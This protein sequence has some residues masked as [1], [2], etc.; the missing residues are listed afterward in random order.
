MLWQ[1]AR[2]LNI[3]KANDYRPRIKTLFSPKIYSKTTTV[4]YVCSEVF[5]SDLRL[6][7]RRSSK[8][9]LPLIFYPSSC[10]FNLAIQ[11]KIHFKPW[12]GMRIKIPVCRQWLQLAQNI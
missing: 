9:F 7:L 1:E 5:A 6:Y 2:L 11:K 12:T 3:S 10:Y 4:F 8:C